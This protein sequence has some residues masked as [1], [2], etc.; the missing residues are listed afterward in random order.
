MSLVI[1]VTREGGYV[2]IDFEKNELRKADRTVGVNC[3]TMF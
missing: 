3:N 2:C 1:T